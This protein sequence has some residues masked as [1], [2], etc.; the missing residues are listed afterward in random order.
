VATLREIRERFIKL[1]G[2]NDLVDDFGMD[3]GAND[4]INAG[5]RLLNRMTGDNIH[6]RSYEMEGDQDSC[7]WSE[8]HPDILLHAA[9]QRLEVSY[10][11]TQGANDWLQAIVIDLSELDKEWVEEA[12]ANLD[13]MEG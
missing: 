5:I 6:A 2:R 4:F 7:F 13:Q 3:R 9:L 10:R 1:S 12:V 11:N 8:L